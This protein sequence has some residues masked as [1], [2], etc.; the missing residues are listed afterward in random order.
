M[1]PQRFFD[2]RFWLAVVLYGIF[3]IPFGGIFIGLSIYWKFWEFPL[4]ESIGILVF[5]IM[6]MYSCVK[7]LPEA[8]SF[9]TIHSDKITWR[10]VPFRKVC[11]PIEDCNFVFITYENRFVENRA[12][13]PENV[14]KPFSIR[15]CL[16]TEPIPEKYK[17]QITAIRRQ[18]GFIQFV[19]SEKL[20]LA[21]I[22][23]L[24]M[25]RTE[26]LRSFYQSN[27]Q[28]AITKT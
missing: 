2:S 3:V 12:W 17:N 24:P 4:W 9:V 28:N 21:L 22:E 5:A 6:L 8:L 10:F 20:A 13:I 16:S 19:Y 14:M 26:Q 7:G 15:I 1:R 23:I 18:K 11:M 27:K 25:E